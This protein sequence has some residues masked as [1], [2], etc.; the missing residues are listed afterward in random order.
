MKGKV[1]EVGKNYC[2]R[3]LKCVK[4]QKIPLPRPVNFLSKDMLKEENWVCHLQLPQFGSKKNF[5]P[6][7]TEY[8]HFG[9]TEEKKSFQTF[10]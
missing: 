8:L 2:G 1:L 5:K 9:K 6:K 3:T 4:V 10:N 7:I